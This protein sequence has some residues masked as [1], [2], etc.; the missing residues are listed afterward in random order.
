MRAA[1]NGKYLLRAGNCGISAIIKPTGEVL[2][3]REEKSKG[4][5]TGEVRLIEQV[6]LY[7]GFKD[8][9]TVF[10]ALL[11]ALAVMKIYKGKKAD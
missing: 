11:T 4:V 2:D 1:E 10:P 6:T 3:L 5:V 9:F 7:S 8:L